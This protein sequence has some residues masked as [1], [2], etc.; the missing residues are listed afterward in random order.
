MKHSNFELPVPVL[1]LVFNR[2]NLT[3]VVFE[4]IR[5]AKPK[6]LYVAADGPRENVESDA[7]DCAR[8]RE[9]VSHIDWD[10]DLKTFFREKNQG[11]KKAVSAA[12]TWFFDHVEKGIIL[13]DDC[14]PA[15]SFFSFCR[16]MLDQYENDERIM[17][18]SGTN[19]RGKWRDDMLDYFFSYYGGIWGWASWRRAWKFFDVDM[20]AWNDPRSA[21]S[22]QNV[23]ANRKQF[24]TRR[25]VFESVYRGEIDTWDYQWSYARLINSGLSLVPSRNLISNIGFNQQA[26]H[27]TYQSHLAN[28]PIYEIKHPL[29]AN[30]YVVAD[31]T[32]DKAFY[33]AATGSYWTRIKRKFLA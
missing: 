20:Q 19:L 13:E 27:T 14:L 18:I 16:D 33:E 5:K 10:C 21:E 4:E 3:K 12:I 9:I 8:T 28:Q 30:S 7:D 29:R 31:R 11:C 6:F 32:Y 24:V 17:Q 15:Q 22:I 2:P 23:L 26:T 1:F 25:K